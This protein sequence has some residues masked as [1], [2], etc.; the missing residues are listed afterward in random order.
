MQ[1]RKPPNIKRYTRFDLPAYKFVPG[2]AEHPSK[3]AEIPHIPHLPSDGVPFSQQNWQQSERYL[4]AID[5]FNLGYYWEVHEVLEKIWLSIGKNSAEGE[6]I[7]GL[8][9]LS[10]ALLKNIVKNH[11]GVKRLYNKALPKLKKQQGIFLGI[12]VEVFLQQFQKL[13]GEGLQPPTIEL[14][15]GE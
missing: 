8:I 10:V 3:N 7:Q 11:Q 4:Y 13:M 9:Q 6:F 1:S 14:K 12:D 15:F 5:L 2:R